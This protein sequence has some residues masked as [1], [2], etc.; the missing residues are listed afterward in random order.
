[1]C[2]SPKTEAVKFILGTMYSQYNMNIHSSSALQ[3]CDLFSSL[4]TI[5]SLI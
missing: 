3:T 4:R 2:Q 1:M 5:A